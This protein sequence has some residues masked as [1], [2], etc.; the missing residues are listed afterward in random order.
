MSLKFLFTSLTF[1]RDVFECV[2]ICFFVLIASAESGTMPASKTWKKNRM[3]TGKFLPSSNISSSKRKSRPQQKHRS[4]S[5]RL[6]SNSEDKKRRGGEV[7][8]HGWSH[9]CHFGSAF[10]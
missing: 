7:C 9:F 6:C 10:S 4:R 3:H 8:L 5:F 2:D 1:Q